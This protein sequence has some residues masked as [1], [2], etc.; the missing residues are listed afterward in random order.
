MVDE[1]VLVRFLFFRR[2]YL[3]LPFPRYPAAQATWEDVEQ[4]VTNASRFIEEFTDAAA[5]E[6][7]DVDENF[8]GIVLLQEA[9]DAGWRDE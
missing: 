2:V 5:K 6:G 8:Y 3:C 7:R 4:T 9:V 1:V